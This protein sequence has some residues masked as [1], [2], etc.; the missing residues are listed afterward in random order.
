VLCSKWLEEMRS[1][2]SILKS[3]R[4]ILHE[5]LNSHLRRRVFIISSGL[6]KKAD[7]LVTFISEIVQK[8]YSSYLDRFEPIFCL[9]LSDEQFKKTQLMLYHSGLIAWD[10]H[11]AGEFIP[12]RFVQS[13][14]KTMIGKK[15]IKKEFHL[16]LLQRKN[17]SAIPPCDD[18]FIL[19]ND[20]IEIEINDARKEVINLS[21]Y[22]YLNY[23][24]HLRKGYEYVG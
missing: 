8:F 5:N 4:L 17:I 16:K 9:D 3:K 15:I 7:Y 18:Y 20:V 2:D 24:F 22:G 10:G 23:I 19:G 1:F 14:P 21:N 12:A 11:F 13:P 6:S